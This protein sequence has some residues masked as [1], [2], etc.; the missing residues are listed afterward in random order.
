MVTLIEGYREKAYQDEKGVWTVGYGHTAG[1]TPHTTCTKTQAIAWLREE[2]NKT[3]EQVS[4][5]L[6]APVTQRQFDALCSL[7]YNVGIG[8]FEHSKLLA[9]I[10]DEDPLAANEFLDWCYV[11]V[12]GVHKKSAGL[13]RRRRQEYALF[14]CDRFPVMPPAA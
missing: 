7:V 8:A 6:K 10:N 4:G 11:T 1:V 12:D 3:A 14:Q 9:R 13:E 2:L 5:A